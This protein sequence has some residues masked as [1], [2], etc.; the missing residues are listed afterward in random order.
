MTYPSPQAYNEALQ[1]PKLSILIPRLAT[2]TVELDSLGMPFGRSG[3]FALTFKITTRSGNNAFRCFLQDRPTMHE[4]YAQ[5]SDYL[6]SQPNPYF[7]KFKYQDAGIR[8]E[9]RALPALE[10]AW[11]S[12]VPL[13]LYIQKNHQDTKKMTALLHK[14]HD[15]AESLEAAGIAHGDIQGGNILVGHQGALKL[16]DYDGMYVPKLRALGANEVGH[17]NFQHPERSTLKPFD[18]TLDR[19]S[20]A[21]IHTALTALIECPNLWV[22]LDAD[23]DKLLLGQSDFADPTSSK[24]LKRIE[25]LDGVGVYAKRLRALAAAPYSKVPKFTDFLA[26]RDIPA[27]KRSEASKPSAARPKG[28]APAWYMDEARREPKSRSGKATSSPWASKVTVTPRAQSN[29]DRVGSLSGAGARGGSGTGGAGGGGPRTGPASKGPIF[30]FG[31]NVDWVVLAL[32]AIGASLLIA[33]LIAS[34]SNSEDNAYVRFPSDALGACVAVGEAGVFSEVDCESDEAKYSITSFLLP[35]ESK[36]PDKQQ[37]WSAWGGDRMACL[38]LIADPSQAAPKFVLYKD[39]DNGKPIRWDRC[40]GP[41]RV[42]VNF[43]SLSEEERASAKYSMSVALLAISEATNADFQ[44]TGETDQVASEAERG[45]TRS[46]D[47]AILISFT[48]PSDADAQWWQDALENFGSVSSTWYTPAQPEWKW[49]F[50]GESAIAVRPSVESNLL[51]GHLLFELAKISGIDPL[52][53]LQE[54]EILGG[55]LRMR[56]YGPGDLAGLAQTAAKT[57]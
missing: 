32:A 42:A 8:V 36:C 47:D 28:A 17:P 48:D 19:F 46:A 55:D 9:G 23:P 13:G 52:P 11:V 54:G 6:D 12:G 26:G 39:P 35:G 51:I 4:R 18:G 3:S 50:I 57:C 38:T 29:T 53:E 27:S 37:R 22:E 16:V 31:P 40:K 15:M 43:G 7:V 5:I 49:N 24:A 25:K 21:V 30:G 20:F 1:N 14:V 2:G 33:W 34:S 10:M 41:I 56:E 45:V 44:F